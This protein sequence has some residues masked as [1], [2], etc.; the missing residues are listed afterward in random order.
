MD[1]SYNDA[2]NHGCVADNDFIMDIILK[3][4]GALFH[5]PSTLMDV[6][7]ATTW[8]RHLVMQAGWNPWR[9]EH[10]ITLTSSPSSKPSKQMEHSAPPPPPPHPP[11][12]ARNVCFFRSAMATADAGTPPNPPPRC[13]SPWSLLPFARRCCIT[14]S[15]NRR[16]IIWPIGLS[17]SPSKSLLATGGH[18]GDGVVAGD[19][20]LAVDTGP[21]GAAQTWLSAISLAQDEDDARHGSEDLCFMEPMPTGQARF[22]CATSRRLW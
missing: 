14:A 7:A 19:G 15:M 20:Q 12:V 2:M 5:R 16:R 21:I 17:S 18:G 3:E 6:G 9:C 11:V 10:G 22:C 4:A 8:R 1:A 13:V